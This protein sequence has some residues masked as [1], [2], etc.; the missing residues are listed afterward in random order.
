MRAVADHYD[1][2]LKTGLTEEEKN[3]LVAYL[4]TL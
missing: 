3:D 2:V 4:R 1:S